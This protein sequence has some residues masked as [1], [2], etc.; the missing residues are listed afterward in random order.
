MTLFRTEAAVCRLGTFPSLASKP[1]N[2]CQR[3]VE[4][5]TS[6][7]DAVHHMGEGDE[8]S[9]SCGVRIVNSG[10]G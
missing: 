3:D 5:T 8:A 9:G 1:D 7:M 6:G 4:H 10:R 2:L